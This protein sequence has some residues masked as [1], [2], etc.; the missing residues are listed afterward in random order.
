MVLRTGWSPTPSSIPGLAPKGSP[1]ENLNLTAD[2][3][4]DAR[5]KQ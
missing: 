2:C 4:F 5:E 1:A 3:Q